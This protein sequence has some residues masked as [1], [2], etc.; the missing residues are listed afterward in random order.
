MVSVQL[1]TTQRRYDMEN[2][3]RAHDRSADRLEEL[4]ASISEVAITHT[5]KRWHEHRHT[6]TYIGFYKK[7]LTGAG[8]FLV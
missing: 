7:H 5:H 1:Q 6:T 2:S 4:Q 3:K 8:C